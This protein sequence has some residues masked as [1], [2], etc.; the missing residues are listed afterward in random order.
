MTKLAILVINRD[1]RLQELGC[2]I[3]MQIHDE[4]IAEFPRETAEEGGKRLAE[5]MI[6]VGSDLIGNKDEI[7]ASRNDIVGEIKYDKSRWSSI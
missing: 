7:K 5:V 2:Q 6:D 3:L 4:I 1:E